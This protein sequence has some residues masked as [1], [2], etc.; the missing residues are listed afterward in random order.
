MLPHSTGCGAGTD[1]WGPAPSGTAC[2]ASHAVTA[3]M[4]AGVIRLAMVAMQSGALAWRRPVLHAAS[5]ASRYERETP[6]SPGTD[7][8]APSR[9]SPW[10]A[11]HAG[12]SAGLS[13]SFARALPRARV[14]SG[15]PAADVES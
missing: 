7:G 5:W 11:L 1:S 3:S 4:S 2:V 15:T 13:P 10:H 12:R 9:L 14:V 8:N 6:N